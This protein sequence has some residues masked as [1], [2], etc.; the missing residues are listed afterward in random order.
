MSKAAHR[1][2]F[3]VEAAED[4]INRALIVYTGFGKSPFPRAR[5]GDLVTLFGDI[6]AADLK[7][8]ILVLYEEM[9]L[10]LPDEPKRSKKS[11]TERAIEQMRLRHPELGTDGLK[12]LAWAYSFGL[13]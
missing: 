3:Q 8:R 11:V 6:A 4:P 7:S 1:Q 9:Q 2:S 12:A 5:T 13:R 10:P